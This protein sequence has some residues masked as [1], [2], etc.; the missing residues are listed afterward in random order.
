RSGKFIIIPFVIAR[1]SHV[2]LEIAEERGGNVATL[3]N[4]NLPSSSFACSTQF[5]PRVRN[6]RRYTLR[7]RAIPLDGS[8]SSDFIAKQNLLP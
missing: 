7:I 5:I 2:T 8:G 1:P 4:E 6:P 3:V